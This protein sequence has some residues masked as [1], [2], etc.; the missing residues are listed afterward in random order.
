M[1]GLLRQ[2]L[3]AG[4][5]TVTSGDLRAL[6]LGPAL[7]Q[8]LVA[9]RL[10]TRVARGAFV[11]TGLLAAADDT[12]RHV[13][14]ATAVARTWPKDVLVS[15]TSAALMHGLPLTVRPDRVHSCRRSTGQHRRTRASTIHGGYR[16]ARSSTIRGVEVLE[17]RFVVLGV[18]E[19]HGRDEAVVVGDAALHRGDVDLAGLKAAADARRHHPAHGTFTSAV[20]V[21]DPAAE[22]PGESRSRLLLLNLGYDPR[23]QVVIRDPAGHVIARVYFLLRG[24][25]VVV[26]FDGLSKY[27]SA[28]ELAAEKRRELR[29]R[30]AGYT[31]VRLLWSDLDRPAKVR[32]LVDAALQADL[33]AG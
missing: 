30:A 27:A 25:R 12:G 7:V 15:H 33:S 5:G 16:D 24:T 8:T 11:D 3:E 4:H 19:L 26:E 28:E 1:E 18:A 22:S 14:R 21:M 2:A 9:R 31:V 10:L 23:S 20:R 29:L 17:P 6:G 13:L 32:A